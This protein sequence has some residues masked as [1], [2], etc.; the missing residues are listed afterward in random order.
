MGTG[1]RLHGHAHT[2]P[3]GRREIGQGLVR[4]IRG[5]LGTR[6]VTVLALDLPI[7]DASGRLIPKS[8]EAGV[9]PTARAPTLLLPALPPYA[10]LSFSSKLSVRR[11]QEPEGSLPSPF[12]FQFIARRRPS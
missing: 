2:R 5:R 7:V 9:D 11:G 10:A 8:R 3:S 4:G 1:V 12:H 6:S